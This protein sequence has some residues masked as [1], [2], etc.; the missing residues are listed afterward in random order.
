MY[1]LLLYYS[2]STERI[3]NEMRIYELS[4][5]KVRGSCLADDNSS[6]W[7]PYFGG[8]CL[9]PVYLNLLFIIISNSCLN[10]SNTQLWGWRKQNPID[11]YLV[12][13]VEV[14]LSHI[15]QSIAARVWFRN[16]HGFSTV[17]MHRLA[18]TISSNTF[19]VAWPAV[20]RKFL[21]ESEV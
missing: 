17:M 2:Y 6:S 15:Y 12:T 11:L 3:P 18:G 5:W 13:N 1:F 21:N 10:G 7:N 9:L 14:W 16:C 19:Q 20:I 4:H 8:C